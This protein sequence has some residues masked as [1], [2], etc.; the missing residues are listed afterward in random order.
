MGDRMRT[1]ALILGL[2]AFAFAACSSSKT[3]V[4]PEETGRYGSGVDLD[5]LEGEKTAP[6]TQAA[7]AEGGQAAPAAPA[8]TDASGNVRPSSDYNLAADK[9]GVGR[10]AYVYLRGARYKKLVFEITAVSGWQP[11][12]GSLN[13]LKARIQGVLDKPDG[14]E[15]A[16]VRTITASKQKYTKEDFINLEERHR[17]RF[18]GTT[19][20]TAVIHM[21][22]LNGEADRPLLGEAYRASSIVIMSERIRQLTTPLVTRPQIEGAVLVHEVGHILRLVNIG[23]KSPRDHADRNSPN[24]SKNVNSVMYYGVEGGDVFSD[25]FNGP[26]PNNFDADD[27]A[28]LADLKAGRLGP[29]SG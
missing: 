28:D 23:Y 18:S 19:G 22:V 16:P 29:Q 27:L 11:D 17:T 5:A 8:A 7:A 2:V 3:Q 20:G 1:F 4:T 10:N 26:P 13:L 15:F 14:I 21:L 24:H 9:E 6:P 12:P 25:I